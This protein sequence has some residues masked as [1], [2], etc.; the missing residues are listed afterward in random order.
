M[1]AVDDI[2]VTP[3]ASY[4]TSCRDPEAIP[5]GRSLSFLDGLYAMSFP[6]KQKNFYHLAT[7][8]CIMESN[9]VEEK[10][11]LVVPIFVEKKEFQINKYAC[12]TQVS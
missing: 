6:F 11:M 12:L 2:R 1:L 3:R 5:D 7:G 9:N 4:R 8:W 10:A